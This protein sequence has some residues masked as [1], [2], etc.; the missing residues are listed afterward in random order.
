MGS[1]PTCRRV[2]SLAGS[3]RA[4]TH[5]YVCVVYAAKAGPT[6]HHSQYTW[7]GHSHWPWPAMPQN[8]QLFHRSAPVSEARK[9]RRCRSVRHGQGGHHWVSCQASGSYRIGTG[10][11]GIAA[12]QRGAGTCDGGGVGGGAFCRAE[13]ASSAY[14]FPTFSNPSK[15]F[16]NG[17]AAAAA[18]TG[19]SSCT[20]MGSTCSS[21]TSMGCATT[22]SL[23]D[24]RGAT[25]SALDGGRGD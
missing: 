24:G 11:A 8:Q 23:D 13:G 1:V 14:T 10:R 5:G 3:C 18:A 17:A 19:E 20:S 6:P 25:T 21:S 12:P 4:R 22:S 16:S 7:C 15:G 9:L 2:C